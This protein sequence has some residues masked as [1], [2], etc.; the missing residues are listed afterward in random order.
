MKAKKV[1]Y[2]PLIFLI[3]LGVLYVF[4]NASIANLVYPFAFSFMFA[5]VWANQKPW[6]VCPAYLAANIIYD[7]SFAN[8]ISSICCVFALV[9]P[10][11]MHILL[12]K[13]IKIW[14]LAIYAGISQIANILFA[15]FYG[16]AYYYNIISMV[17]G[18]MFM[19]I[20]IFILDSFFTKGITK[21]LN[22][23][24]LIITASG[25]LSTA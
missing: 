23:I 6:I 25:D 15:Y 5:L 12:K 8:I 18:I 2:Y 14:E 7:Y 21:R 13:N 22:I 9:V 20:S 3:F 11:Y 1:L 10:Y 19:Y 4:E 16:Q 24:E 17:V